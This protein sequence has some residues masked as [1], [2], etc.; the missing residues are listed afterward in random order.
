VNGRWLA[1]TFVRGSA[2]GGA[3]ERREWHKQLWR[4][5]VFKTSYSNGCF[6]FDIWFRYGDD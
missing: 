6:L 4:I 5:R 1:F 2:F 3:G